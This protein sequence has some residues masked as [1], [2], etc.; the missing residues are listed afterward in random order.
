MFTGIIESLGEVVE[1][2]TIDGNS[3]IKIKSDISKESYIDQSIAHN[4]VCLTVTEKTDEWHSVT[5][6]EET[7]LKSNIGDLK[8]GDELNL[9]R[10]M[11]PNKRLDGHF[12]QGHVDDKAICREVKA[13]DGS[14]Y[15]TFEYD[16]KHIS[17][18]VDKGSVCIN[19]TSLTIV[20]PIENTFKVAIIPYTYEHTNFK[21]FVPGSKVNIEFDILGKYVAKMMTRQMENLMNK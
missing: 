19:G 10:A 15:Y 4:G 1:V 18:I 13:L 9:E 8:P 7:L 14:W 5:A 11:L 20:E 6:I 2:K 16:A 12:V 3:I 17:L 21:H